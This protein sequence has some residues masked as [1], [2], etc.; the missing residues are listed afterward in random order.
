MLAALF[1]A[2]SAKGQKSEESSTLSRAGVLWDEMLAAKGG[3]KLSQVNNLVVRAHLACP[4]DEAGFL[5]LFI[6]RRTN[7]EALWA[8]PDR[9]YDTALYAA[10]DPSGANF[11]LF[12]GDTG[13][14]W[15]FF[16]SLGPPGESSNK[17]ALDR[18]RGRLLFTQIVYL[19][20]TRWV[21]PI[22]VGYSREPI[23]LH[24]VDVVQTRLGNINA[25]FYLDGQT[26]LPL[27]IKTNLSFGGQVLQKFETYSLSDYVSTAGIEF[28]SQI[29]SGLCRMR[30][31]YE[32]NVHYDPRFFEKAPKVQHEPEPWREASSGDERL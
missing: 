15:S 6:W 17:G 13:K 10:K 23:H 12:N 4:D 19:G 11:S 7:T 16:G 28:P 9:F 1:V 18:A 27:K 3:D 24:A 2:A 31:Q 29:S 20:E 8:F 14:F 25:D 5:K 22:P 30:V 21:K 32:I 26:H